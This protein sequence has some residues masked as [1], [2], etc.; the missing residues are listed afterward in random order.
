MAKLFLIFTCITMLNFAASWVREMENKGLYQG[1][2]VL[3]P[4]Q[5]EAL[6]KAKNTF[7]SVI[8]FRWPNGVVPY[9][10]T[11]SIGNDGYNAVQQAIADYHKHTC[12]KFE[13]RTNQREYIKFVDGG[14]CSSPV[15]F[16]NPRYTSNG[17]NLITLGVGCRSKDTAMHEMG[18]SIGLYHE[19]SRPDRDGYVTIL[20]HNVYNQRMVFNFNKVNNINSLNTPYDYYSMMH[21][22]QTAF[23]CDDNW[24]NC[25]VTIRTKDPNMQTVIG[26]SNGFSKGDIKQINLMYNCKG[27]GTGGTG[28]GG[29]TTCTDSDS[30]CPY[31]QS[32]GECYKNPNWM[33]RNCR[34]S[35]RQ[36]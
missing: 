7:G 27:T 15:G 3:R 31:W 29:G 20:K 8:G 34:K 24:R 36:C 33:L 16:N 2:M 22:D 1:D 23:G 6:E 12:L 5:K 17:V 32:I 4:D 28:T 26:R 21:Y 13:R 18:H 10:I 14:G 11:S 9:V 30:K 19:Q 35:C 25:K